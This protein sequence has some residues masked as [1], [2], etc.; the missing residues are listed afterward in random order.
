MPRRSFN[1]WISLILRG[2]ALAMGV[3]T[4]ILSILGTSTP[5]SLITLVGIGLAAL[6]LWALQSE[7][8]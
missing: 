7:G 3:A 6:G 5:S 8:S 1:G 2:L 4:V